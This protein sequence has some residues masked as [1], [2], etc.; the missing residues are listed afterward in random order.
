MIEQHA[1]RAKVV[2]P[3]TVTWQKC[4]TNSMPQLNAVMMLHFASLRK[5][6]RNYPATD[7]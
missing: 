7:H 3:I 6:S 2:S 1:V 5:F 4:C